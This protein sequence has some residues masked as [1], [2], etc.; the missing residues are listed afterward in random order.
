[1]STDR[2]Q[3]QP[4]A[5]GET[6]SLWDEL[7]LVE[8]WLKGGLRRGRAKPD[9]ASLAGEPGESGEAS[10]AAR[11][12]TEAEAEAEARTQVAETGPGAVPENGDAG[13]EASGPRPSGLS[14]PARKEAAE[15]AGLLKGMDREVALCSACRLATGR[16]KSVFGMGVPNPTVLVVGEGPGGEEDSSG[17]PFV[18]PAGQL[19]DKM[20]SA[21][22]VSRSTNAYIANIVKCRPPGNR[23]PAPDEMKACIGWLEAQIDILQPKAILC[24]GRIA[25]QALTGSTEGITKLRGRWFE[26]RGIPL[27]ATFHP[28]ALLRDEAYKRPAW[29]DL[30]TLREK[31]GDVL[32]P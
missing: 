11:A 27:L 15:V 24:L 32:L 28:S 13:A 14:L 8:D 29:E 4:D 3:A 19:L 10:Q 1:M 22:G 23:D 17:L 9:F 26:H 2:A 6:E 12:G 31:L 18:G 5:R 7:S 25:T 21:I 16:K 20:L 30:K